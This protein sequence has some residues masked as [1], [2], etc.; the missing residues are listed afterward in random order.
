L[1]FAEEARVIAPLDIPEVALQQLD[2]YRIRSYP[3]GTS[4]ANPLDAALDVFFE[5]REENVRRQRTILLLSDGRPTVPNEV[6]GK[7]RALAAAGRLGEIGIPVRAYALGPDALADPDFYRSLAERSGGKFVAVENPADAVDEFANVQFAGLA[8]VA[9]RSAPSGKPGRAVRVFPNGAFDGYVPLSEGENVIS[10]T[11][12]VENGEVLEATR[13]VYFERPGRPDAAD[14]QQAEQLR[15]RLQDRVVELELLQ[16][17]R[18]HPIQL[19]RLELGIEPVD[20]R[21]SASAPVVPTDR[22]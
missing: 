7:R 14:E 1:T 2:D 5:A 9:I 13:T 16:E 4:L 15:K 17:M 10:I 8:N 3:S 21:P 20:E 22:D 18:R 6:Q 19:R 11:A 12:T